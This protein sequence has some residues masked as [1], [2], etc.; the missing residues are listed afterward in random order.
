MLLKM[1]PIISDSLRLNLGTSGAARAPGAGDTDGCQYLSFSCCESST[2]PTDSRALTTL[3]HVG[4]TLV[5]PFN[6]KSSTS[7]RSSAGLV[8]HSG[9]V[10]CLNSSS[11]IPSCC[12]ISLHFSLTGSSSFDKILSSGTEVIDN[13]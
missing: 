5:L 9:C 11:T 1:L 10:H 12:P 2:S 4:L 7:Q 3:S 6:Q 13:A 8:N